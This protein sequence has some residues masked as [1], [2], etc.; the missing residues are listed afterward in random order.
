MRTGKYNKRTWSPGDPLPPL[1][2]IRIRRARHRNNKRILHG[3]SSVLIKTS[4]G[5]RRIARFDNYDDACDFLW[6][7]FVE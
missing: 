3:K 5:W 1:V 6:D 2:K 4:K 7:Y